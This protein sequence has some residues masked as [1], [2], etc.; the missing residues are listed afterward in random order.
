LES[1]T[2]KVTESA[3]ESAKSKVL[4]TRMVTDLVLESARA[5]LKGSGKATLKAGL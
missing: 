1:A 2:G 3:K 5:K 4:E